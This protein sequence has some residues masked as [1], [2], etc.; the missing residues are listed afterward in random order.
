MS[1]ITLNNLTRLL[2][3]LKPKTVSDLSVNSNKLNVTFLDN[4]T[5]ELTLPSGGGSQQQTR[6]V[7]KIPLYFEIHFG[8][9]EYE[10]AQY[11]DEPQGQTCALPISVQ[12]VKKSFRLQAKTE[13]SNYVDINVDDIQV[14]DVTENKKL[15][16]YDT[17]ILVKVNLPSVYTLKF[18]SGHSLRFTLSPFFSGY[19]VQD[20]TLLT[21]INTRC[22]LSLENLTTYVSTLSEV[23]ID[24]GGCGD[25]NG[26]NYFY[27]VAKPGSFNTFDDEDT[28]N[29]KVVSAFNSSYET[30][31][32]Y[33]SGTSTGILKLDLSLYKREH[34]NDTVTFTTNV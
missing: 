1:L 22:D 8:F 34:K 24:S 16:D 4:H 18:L 30:C 28:S 2:T 7:T 29:G 11:G 31:F 3:G 12:D 13:N 6:S 15:S 25:G 26:E 33:S 17:V 19:Q 27:I 14:Q 21:E 10:D 23:E 5:K 20:T 9:G 32:V